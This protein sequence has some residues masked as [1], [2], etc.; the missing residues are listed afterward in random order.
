M[1][2]FTLGE[3]PFAGQVRPA[4]VTNVWNEATGCVNLVV[5]KDQDA[6]GGCVEDDTFRVTSVC[7]H[8]EGQDAKGTWRWPRREEPVQETQAAAE[9]ESQAEEALPPAEETAQA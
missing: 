7:K 5:F 4:M 3:G 2:R 8:V 9:S 6:D 1:V